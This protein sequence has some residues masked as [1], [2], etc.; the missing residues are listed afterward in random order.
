MQISRPR[1][2]PARQAGRRRAAGPARG[3]ARP[4]AP[5]HSGRYVAAPR[6]WPRRAAARGPPTPARAGVHRAHTA[7][8]RPLPVRPPRGAARLV[9]AP[10]RRRVRHG[11]RGGRGARGAQ[12]AAAGRGW[13][14][15]APPPPPARSAGGCVARHSGGLPRVSGETA[16][17]RGGG[18]RDSDAGGGSA[19]YRAMMAHRCGGTG[20][21]TR[22]NRTGDLRHVD[23][24]RDLWPGERPARRPR[25]R[26]FSDGRRRA[27]SAGCGQRLTAGLLHRRHGGAQR[28]VRVCLAAC[29]RGPLRPRAETVHVLALQRSASSGRLGAGGGAQRGDHSARMHHQSGRRLGATTARTSGER[30]AR[31]GT[32]CGVPCASGACALCVNVYSAS[33]AFA[34]PLP[35]LLSQELSQRPPR[36]NRHVLRG[37]S[38]R[39]KRRA[40]VLQAP[41]RRPPASPGPRCTARG[42]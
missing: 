27:G 15:G 16:A 6:D 25:A 17:A 11:G 10:R 28:Q 8:G 39:C 34:R 4:P 21:A 37:V 36:G 31:A 42:V 12:R 24:V 2:A 23:G 7:Y 1:G 32:G 20:P 19:K 40:T 9:G 13:P 3:R 35:R 29:R 30:H 22:V 41:Q 38:P 33:V 5:P 18:I 26:K 14:G